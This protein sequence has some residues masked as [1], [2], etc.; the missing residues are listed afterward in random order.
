MLPA[1]AVLELHEDI[2][3]NAARCRKDRQICYCKVVVTVTQQSAKVSYWLTDAN[4]AGHLTAQKLFLTY[5]YTMD[6]QQPSSKSCSSSEQISASQ[7]HITP[8]SQ[9]HW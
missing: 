7:A 4:S 8:C 1:P 5:K 2:V 6:F 9:C 3:T